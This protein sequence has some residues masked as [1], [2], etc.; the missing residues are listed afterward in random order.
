MTR[1]EKVEVLKAK[2]EA[3]IQWF[4]GKQLP[5]APIKVRPWATIIDTQVFFERQLLR[6]K[7]HENNPFNCVYICAYYE[8]LDLKTYM[9]VQGKDS[10]QP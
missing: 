6:I 3:L 8:L 9:D 4:H 1:S 10:S 5:A 2:T 7:A